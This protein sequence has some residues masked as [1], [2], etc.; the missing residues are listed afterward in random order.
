MFDRLP[1]QY[2]S[3]HSETKQRDFLD[4]FH[5][6]LNAEG[7]KIL[8]RLDRIFKDSPDLLAVIKEEEKV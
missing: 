8:D 4:D 6:K 2:R 7:S 1:R 3:P 5:R